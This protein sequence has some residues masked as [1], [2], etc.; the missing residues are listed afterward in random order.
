MRV[1]VVGLGLIGGSVALAARE[2]AGLEVVG[3]DPDPAVVERALERGA[4]TSGA[5]SLAGAVERADVVVAAAPVGAL[6]DLVKVALALAP[7]DCV[8]TDVGS[9]KLAL[10]SARSDPRFIGGHPLAGAAQSG[11]ERARA[12]LFERALWY[13]TPTATT[14]SASIERARDL[15]SALGAEAVVLDAELHDELMAVVSQLPHVFANTLVLAAM[16]PRLGGRLAPGPS[17]RDATRVAGAN[18]QMWT[19]IYTS[20]AAVLARVLDDVISEFERLRE[21]LAEGDGPAL[22]VWNDAAAA[23]REALQERGR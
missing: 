13:L 12:D 22:A 23:A 14:A 17:F 20:N 11:I 6:A 2:R 21:M 4:I 18:T 7:A 3:W 15:V 8:V 1:T 10:A 16:A 5:G 19:D 9:T